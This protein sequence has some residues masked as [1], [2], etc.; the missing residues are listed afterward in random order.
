VWRR[1]IRKQLRSASIAVTARKTSH[2]ASS[3]F[4]ALT[5]KLLQRIAAILLRLGL[6]SP[7]AE[8]LLRR[9][10]VSAALQKTGSSGKRPTQSELASIAGLSRLEVRTLLRDRHRKTHPTSR[11]DQVVL[12]WENDPMFLDSRGKPSALELRGPGKTFDRLAK[13]YGRDVTTRTLR[14]ELIRRK[15]A[16]L[17]GKKLTLVQ[18][19]RHFSNDR[20]AAH[21]DLKFLVSQLGSIDFQLGRRAYL[22]R[23][24]SVLVED[25]KGVEMVKR[26]AVERLET[27]LS[28]LTEMSVDARKFE[29][30][31][32]RG[33][34]L[35]ITTIVATEAED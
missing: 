8:W 22:T 32:R 33:R 19:G 13:K 16:E 17:K 10:F 24:S 28:S 14:V 11:I 31:G 5:T 20:I 18:K 27:V 15:I 25:K 6:D 34:R 7:S 35:M 4:D 9:A 30:S 3:D 29:R 2:R 12:G 23:Q 21:T 26:I 1:A